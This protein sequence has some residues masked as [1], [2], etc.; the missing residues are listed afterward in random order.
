[1]TFDSGKGAVEPLRQ[2]VKALVRIGVPKAY[3]L[4]VIDLAIPTR[5]PG[6]GVDALRFHRDV[7]L[8][9]P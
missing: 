9:A 6:Q 1:M 5:N 4:A 8:P 2:L 7:Q 3:D